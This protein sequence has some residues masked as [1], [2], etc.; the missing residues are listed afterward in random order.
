MN[1]A[2]PFV[3]PHQGVTDWQS[4]QVLAIISQCKSP[5]AELSMKMWN[6]TALGV[7]HHNGL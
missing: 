2:D 4:V 5:L 1:G 3:L 7:S 6:V